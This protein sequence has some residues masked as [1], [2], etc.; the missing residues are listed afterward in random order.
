[1]FSIIKNGVTVLLVILIASCSKGNLT[2]RLEEI[3]HEGDS[4]PLTALAMLDSL[5]MEVRESDEYTKAKYD[6]LR[7]R[8]NDKA[9]NIPN[10]DIAIKKLILYFEENGSNLDKQEVYYYAGSV[11]RDLQD[12]PRALANFFKSLDYTTG[13]NSCDSIMMRNAYSN[14]TYL[15]F[16]VQDYEDAL[17]MAKKEVSICQQMKCD[18]V[19]PYMHEG[20]SYVALDSILKA[21][22]SFGTAYEQMLKSKDASKYQDNIFYLMWEYADIGEKEKAR[23]CRQ[24]LKGVS[25]TDLS[26]MYCMALAVYYESAG[27]N[28]SARIYCER[29]LDNGTDTE[30]MYD[31]A[32]LLFKIYKKNGDIANAYESAN[33]YMQLSDSLDFGKRQELAATVSNQYKYNLDLKREQETI[34]EKERYKSILWV[35]IMLSVILACG[36]YALYI[37]RR[38][39]HLQ[40]VL[41]LSS[42]LQRLS[43][44]ERHLHEEIAAKEKLLAEREEQNRT[45]MRLLNQSELEAQAEEV[46]LKMK[47]SASGKKNMKMSDWKLLYKAVDELFPLFKDKMLKE[48]GAF[49]EQQMQVCYLMRAGFYKQQIQNMTNLSRVTVWRWTN[50]FDWVFSTDDS[51][52]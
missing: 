9:D 51:R 45:F 6:L 39:K 36:A 35:V 23:E 17:S 30:N 3:K 12:T 19:V 50:K 15:Y 2:D 10:S 18:I 34:I 46:L 37:R 21:K 29:V 22:K 8:L 38:N 25:S 28:D 20:E 13:S 49:S 42:E 27:M 5:E 32:K 24:H 26:P 41:A 44:A 11:Y 47:E 4:D 1:M 16:K 52:A 31:A 33:L 7:I 48:L 40:E 43:E 14:L